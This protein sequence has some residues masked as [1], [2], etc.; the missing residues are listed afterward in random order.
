MGALLASSKFQKLSSRD[1]DDDGDSSADE[2]GG[3]R[4]GDEADEA[5][6]V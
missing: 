6:E 1:D 4:D 5:W 2:G 3:G